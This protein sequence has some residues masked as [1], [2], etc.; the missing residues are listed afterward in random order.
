MASEKEANS[1]RERY[2][3]LLRK[4]GAHS[5]AVDERK[6]GGEK[7]F[8]VIAFFDR[9]PS[10]AVPETLEVRSGKRTVEVPLV[11]EIMKTPSAE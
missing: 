1:A 2:S 9:K 3:D 10:K 5:I 8:A 4:L 6:R 7:S 11:A